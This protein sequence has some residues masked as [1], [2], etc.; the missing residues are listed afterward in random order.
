ME[1]IKFGKENTNSPKTE[2]RKNVVQHKAIEFKNKYPE[3]M[4][5]REIIKNDAAKNE[6]AR[7]IEN[8]SHE[9]EEVVV[10]N[11]SP[12]TR[13]LCGVMASMLLFVGVYLSGIEAPDYVCEAVMSLVEGTVKAR[14]AEDS[15]A[16]NT[17]VVGAKVLVDK[18]SEDNLQKSTSKDEDKQTETG[19]NQS[20]AQAIKEAGESGVKENTLAEAAVMSKNDGKAVEVIAKNMSKGSDKLYCTNKTDLVIDINEYLNREYPIEKITKADRETPKVLIIHTHGTE[21]YIDTGDAENTRTSDTERNVVRVGKELA[22]VLESYGIS[23]IHSTTM[24]DEIS[25]VNAYANSKKEAK[26]YL[27]KYPSIRYIIDVHRD[28]IGTEENPVKTHAEINGESAAQ[29]MFVMG[30]NASGGNHPN[31][32]KNLTV[33]AY[34][35]KT[36][37]EL[38]PMLMRPINIRPIIFNQNLADGC[39]ILEVGSDANTMNEALASVRMFGRVFAQTVA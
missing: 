32:E 7:D 34:L 8:K 6:K 21:A 2:P 20:F 38:F 29:L 25:Y 4:V 10:E 26:E 11:N 12:F 31:F 13:V 15:V 16:K 5:K 3:Y 27:E 22:N 19:E 9:Q 24:H 14:E 18:I 39:M 37:N 36:A 35:Q 28:A 1:Y 17:K 30:T 23:V 33:A